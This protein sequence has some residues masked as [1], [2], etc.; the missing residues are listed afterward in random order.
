M[1]CS[2]LVNYENAVIANKMVITKWIMKKI[3]IP[4]LKINVEVISTLS[5]FAFRIAKITS[6]F[7]QRL[8]SNTNERYNVNAMFDLGIC[9]PKLQKCC[10][11]EGPFGSP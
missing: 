5:S 2:F 3:T 1:C 4:K 9:S 10:E 8:A 11:T 7:P 6:E